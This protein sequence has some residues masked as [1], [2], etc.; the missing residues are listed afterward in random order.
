MVIDLNQDN[1]K[2]LHKLFQIY[3]KTWLSAL[4]CSLFWVHVQKIYIKKTKS[5]T[6]KKKNQQTNTQNRLWL[7]M[8]LTTV[9]EVKS[10]TSL[11]YMKNV[12]ITFIVSIS[13]PLNDIEP[14]VLIRLNTVHIK[15]LANLL[16]IREKLVPYTEFS[17]GW[18]LCLCLFPLDSCK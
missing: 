12:K 6:K 14:R 16:L 3:Y 1:Y 2:Y 10:Q 8:V 18:S 4:F 17:N 5:K 11:F 13:T 9:K 7:A 15:W